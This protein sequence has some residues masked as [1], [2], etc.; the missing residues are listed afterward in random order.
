MY[1]S[2]LASL[3]PPSSTQLLVSSTQTSTTTNFQIRGVFTSSQNFGLESSVGLYVDGVYRARQG[4]MIN[5]L[6]DNFSL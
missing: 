2:E 4:S 5:N 1:V 6:V 3:G